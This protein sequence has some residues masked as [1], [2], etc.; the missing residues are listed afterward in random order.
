MLPCDRPEKPRKVYIIPKVSQK[1]AAQIASGEFKPKERKP[2]KVNPD[3]KIKP[4]SDKRAK[5]EREYSKLAKDYKI[6]NPICERCHLPPSTD[7]HHMKGRTGNLLTDE[8][9][10]IALCRWCHDWAEN[11]PTQ[12]KAEGISKSRLTN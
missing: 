5:Q 7:V 6:K 3:Y 8:N 4:R 11:H 9:N 1:R 2:I 10:F 12:A